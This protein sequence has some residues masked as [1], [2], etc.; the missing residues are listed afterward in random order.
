M[1]TDRPSF[2]LVCTRLDLAREREEQE[3]TRQAES[4]LATSKAGRIAT[5]GL[6]ARLSTPRRR[7]LGL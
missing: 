4:R 1:V 7:G 5:P 6:N 2:F 3:A